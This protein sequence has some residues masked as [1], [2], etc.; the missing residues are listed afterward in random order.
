M[1]EDRQ[2]ATTGQTV[3]PR[4]KQEGD[5]AEMLWPRR[6]SRKETHPAMAASRPKSRAFLSPPPHFTTHYTHQQKTAVTGVRTPVP[7]T[8]LMGTKERTGAA[9]CRG[10]QT[11][12]PSVTP[13]MQ[14]ARNSWRTRLPAPRTSRQPRSPPRPCS[15]RVLGGRLALDRDVGQRRQFEGSCPMTPFSYQPIVRFAPSQALTFV[16]PPGEEMTNR[17]RPGPVAWLVRAS[18]AA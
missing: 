7:A 5:R 12:M 4:R 6:R 18:A 10:T 11:K 3:T 8:G 17:E 16:R 9:R 2:N 1:K 13:F 14:K 15:G